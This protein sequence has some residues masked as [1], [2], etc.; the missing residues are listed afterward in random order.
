MEEGRALLDTDLSRDGDWVAIQVGEPDGT[1]A[2]YAVPVSAPPAG[3]EDWIKIAGD[4]HWLGAPRWSVNGSI[5]YYISER[6]DFMCVWGQPLDPATKAPIGD[7]FSVAHA[8]TSSMRMTT[9]RRTMWTLDVGRD[10]LVFNAGEVTGDVYTA[11][12][13]TE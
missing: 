8:H 3:P 5:L 4:K 2:V 6:D 7:P 10:R 13:D 9:V 12:L 11:M 1:V